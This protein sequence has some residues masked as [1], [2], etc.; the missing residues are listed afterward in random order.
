MGQKTGSGPGNKVIATTLLEALA[1]RGQAAARDRAMRALG[2]AEGGL[3]EAK[4]WLPDG[5][6]GRMF[7]AVDADPSLVRS[8]GHRL[9]S[10]DATGLPLYGLGLASPE[11][12]Y[13]RVRSLLPRE[14]AESFWVVDEIGSGSA[15][16]HF[17]DREIGDESSANRPAMENP[18]AQTALCALRVGMLEAVPGLYGLLPASVKESTCLSR[19]ADAC[20][21]EIV[22]KRNSRLG[23]KVGGGIGLVFAVSVVAVAATLGLPITATVFPA[24]CSLAFGAAI[25]QTIDL[26]R[27]LEAVAGARRGH[28]ALFDQVDDALASKLDALARADAK[29][30]GTE[31]GHRADRSLA[32]SDDTAAANAPNR[33]EILSAA[34][35]IHAAAG[36]LE[37][38]FEDA[39]AG[40][41]GGTEKAV[42]EAREL[43]RE[44]RKWAA[45]ISEEG[46]SENSTSQ[47]SVDLEVLVTRAIAAA[48]P[49]LPRSA[50]I[51]VDL[52]DD[53]TPVACEPVQ[54]EQVIVQLLRNAVEASR[55]LTESPE[56]TV[57]LRKL[58]RGIEIA[59]EDRGVGIEP[60]EIDEV[61][62]PFF[63]DRRAG[64]DEGFGLPVCLRIVERH[65][66]ELRIE[67]EDRP[68]TRVSVL[69]PE[70]PEPPA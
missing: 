29:L 49:M 14:S 7:A 33:V 12:A 34:E 70:S 44:I 16:I 27:Q 62:D 23:L 64:L 5:V 15:R 26:H 22:W 40:E 67:T 10:P 41:L 54:I 31:P 60:S 18:R 39:A 36:D 57:S 42:G 1:V 56:V 61:F 43:V 19:G 20:R 4:A 8:V 50:I 21:Y 11:K 35:N 47:S 68:G 37:C 17:H 69:L 28:L 51:K 30:E 48:R 25:G 63:G 3:A 32:D 65:G 13:R 59:V 38:W 45:Q 55:S 66:G 2:M 46:Q 24:L 58:T 52:D 53:L 9:V 6:L